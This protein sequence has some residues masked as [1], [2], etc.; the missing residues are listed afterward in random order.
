MKAS[1]LVAVLEGRVPI[2]VFMREISDEVENFR[3]GLQKKGSS[4]PIYVTED[5]DGFCIEPA[6][7]RCLSEAFLEGQLD[8][9][10]LGY[11]L[12]GIELSQCFDISSESLEQVVSHLCELA[13]TPLTRDYVLGQLRSLET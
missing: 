2:E 6:H 3:V 13:E 11:V 5:I 7:V 8:E 4:N 12:T 9:I 10:D 1:T